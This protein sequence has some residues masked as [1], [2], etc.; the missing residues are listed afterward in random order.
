MSTEYSDV[1]SA[2]SSSAPADTQPDAQTQDPSQPS[3]T[4]TE[5]QPFH[6]HPRFRELTTRNREQAQQIQQLTQ[7]VNEL[8]S[9]RQ[10]SQQEGT[11]S[12]EEFQAI[13]A[14]KKLIA[15]DPELAGLLNATKQL[16]QFQQRFQ[17]FDQSQA[18]AAKAHNFAAKSA[19][20][21]MAE[22]SGLKV[23]DAS[24]KH[25]VRLVAGAAMELE[26]GNERYSS[27]DLS[28]LQE[29]FD[30]IKP[31]LEALRK[32]A[33]VAVA[34]TKNKLRNMPP[35]PRGSAAGQPAPPKLDQGGDTR[36]YEASLHQRAKEMLAGM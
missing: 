5:T 27:G 29:A 21:E 26:Q 12:Q 8:R 7:A 9:A 16:P 31:W 2:D 33:E 34:N 11:M 22:A 35:A 18:Q 28:V 19:I 6:L 23:D 32:P 36:K 20:R 24:M 4:Q 17:Q 14:L 3:P 30:Q 1:A 15:K 25:I 10:T 13:S